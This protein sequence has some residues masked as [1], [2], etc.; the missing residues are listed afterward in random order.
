MTINVRID[1]VEAGITIPFVVSS[2]VGS[3]TLSLLL[4]F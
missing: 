1:N 4:L 3:M 2:I